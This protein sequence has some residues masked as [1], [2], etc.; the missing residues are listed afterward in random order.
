MMNLSLIRRTGRRKFFAMLN[1]PFKTGA[2]RRKLRTLGGSYLG[3]EF[4]GLGAL[5]DEF[6]G[7][8]LND[9]ILHEKCTIMLQTRN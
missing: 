8:T 9:T 6:L 5:A 4:G 7:T 3:F 2:K 1:V